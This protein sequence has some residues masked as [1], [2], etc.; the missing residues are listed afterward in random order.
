MWKLG[1][2]QYFLQWSP[3][4]Y[5][6]FK[7][8]SVLFISYKSVI[9]QNFWNVIQEW[10]IISH[11]LYSNKT[12]YYTQKLYSF[13]FY[14]ARLLIRKFLTSRENY[15]WNGLLF[16]FSLQIRELPNSRGFS[17]GTNKSRTM[18]DNCIKKFPRKHIC[19]RDP[20]SWNVVLPWCFYVKRH[21]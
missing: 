7:L 18:R 3:G 14:F 21:T 20:K 2:C 4:F 9:S 12:W 15:F 17:A 5:F 13:P 11:H 1:G 10:E 19:G 6:Y 16:L 8:S